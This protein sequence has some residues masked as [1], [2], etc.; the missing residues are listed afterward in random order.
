MMLAYPWNAVMFCHVC[1]AWILRL[2]SGLSYERV[3]SRDDG[4]ARR[5]KARRGTE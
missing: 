4:R 2:A 5:R 3:H 1:L